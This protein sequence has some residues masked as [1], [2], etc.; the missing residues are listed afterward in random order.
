MRFAKAFLA[1]LVLLAAVAGTAAAQNELEAEAVF[2]SHVYF[3][4]GTG[5][6][7]TT[8]GGFATQVAGDVYNSTNPLSTPIAGFSSGDL[9]AWM[10]DRVTTT[11]TGV[12][13][14]NDFTVFNG[15][16]SAGPLTSVSFN[17]QFFD[18]GTAASLGGFTTGVLNLGAGL[19]PGQFTIVTVTG[20]GGLNINL[21]T[22]DVLV[23]QR[24]VTK[25]GAASR[26]GVALIDP[27]TIGSSTNTMYLFTNVNAEG[28]YNIGNPPINAN[29]GYRIN[30]SQPVPATA[31]S[32]GAIKAF[33]KN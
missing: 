22:T 13:Q 2:H 18:A 24:V 14:A 8:K 16:S 32:W 33:Y 29:P 30:V 3:D 7:Y 26:L 12:L 31:K 5:L 15:G 28:F 1:T 17:V 20:L 25:T 4:M 11:G 19:L 9:N 6:M 21:N 27:P 10:G 23:R